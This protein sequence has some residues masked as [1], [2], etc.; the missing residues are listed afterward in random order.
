MRVIIIVI[1]FCTFWHTA[2]GEEFNNDDEF[3]SSELPSYE[4]E[5]DWDWDWKAR[6]R[7]NKSI[8]DKNP[9]DLPQSKPQPIT[10]VESVNKRPYTIRM[11]WNGKNWRIWQQYLDS[12]EPDLT[13]DYKY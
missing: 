3:N 12:P 2:L 6:P 5:I 7:W 9:W 13:K 8:W 4:D 1:G 10:V 11:H